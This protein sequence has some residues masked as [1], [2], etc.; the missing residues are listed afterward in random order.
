MRECLLAENKE[1]SKSTVLSKSDCAL[2]LAN[3]TATASLQPAQQR[4]PAIASRVPLS[5]N[6]HLSFLRYSP[7]TF[8]YFDQKKDDVALC[9]GVC[10]ACVTRQYL[11]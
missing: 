8:Q 2:G 1:Y 5:R 3:A 11:S 9:A 4:A 7:T 6:D 10:T